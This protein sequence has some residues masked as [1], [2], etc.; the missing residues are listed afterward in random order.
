M[1]KQN[2]QSKVKMQRRFLNLKSIAMNHLSQI[3]SQK[4]L[5]R[6][7]KR[8]QTTNRKKKNNLKSID[9][10]SSILLVKSYEANHKK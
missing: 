5:L 3:S 9:K 2:H 10:P 1:Q 8:K 6:Q 4:I 7:K